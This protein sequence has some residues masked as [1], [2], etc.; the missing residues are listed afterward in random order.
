MKHFIYLV[1]H[2]VTLLFSYLKPSG[3]KAK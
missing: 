2:L 3:I 1:L